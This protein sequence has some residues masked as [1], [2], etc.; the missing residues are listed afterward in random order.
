MSFEGG[1]LFGLFGSGFYQK[2]SIY[3]WNLAWKLYFYVYSPLLPYTSFSSFYYLSFYYYLGSFL[4][5]LSQNEYSPLWVSW[6]RKDLMGTKALR[7]LWYGKATPNL[8]EED[9]VDWK[10]LEDN[11]FLIMII[12]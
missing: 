6:G 3:F 4:L 7:L 2:S 8:K 1:G 12:I 9:I 10:N 5:F 11:A